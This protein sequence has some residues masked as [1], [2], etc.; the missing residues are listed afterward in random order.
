MPLTRDLESRLLFKLDST[1]DIQTLHHPLNKQLK[2]C[3][4]AKY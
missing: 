2:E 4:G 3:C 1:V